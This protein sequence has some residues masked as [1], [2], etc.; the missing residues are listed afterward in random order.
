MTVVADVMTRDVQVV[1]EY[2]TLVTAAERMRESDVSALPICAEDGHVIGM[3]TDR[4]IVVKCIA[5]GAAAQDVVSGRLAS[6]KVLA[7]SAH[8]TVEVVVRVMVDHRVWRLPVLD[9][10]ALVGVISKAD[11]ITVLPPAQLDELVHAV[12][13]AA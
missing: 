8:D 7:V 2:E 11:L 4:D 1:G 10:I 13:A 12:N 6:G 9:G 5:E 3:L